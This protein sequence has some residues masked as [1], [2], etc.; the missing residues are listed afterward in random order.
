MLNILVEAIKEVIKKKDFKPYWKGGKYEDYFAKKLHEYLLEKKIIEYPHNSCYNG[1]SERKFDLRWSNEGKNIVCEVGHE[2]S[3]RGNLNRVYKKNKTKEKND[4]II[5]KLFFDYIKNYQFKGLIPTSYAILF[6]SIEK[7]LDN[8]GAKNLMNL[9]YNIFSP[10]CSEIIEFKRANELLGLI[11][12][13]DKINNFDEVR[14]IIKN[15]K[16]LLN[17]IKDNEKYPKG[18]GLK[19]PKHNILKGVIKPWEF[20]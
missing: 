6:F 3:T 2:K 9:I 18:K 1:F 10:K 13:V 20:K 11:L 19:W 5:N 17:Y 7:E 15:N 8:D 12:V 14:N 16:N 4:G